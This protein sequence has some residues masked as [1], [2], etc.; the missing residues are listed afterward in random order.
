MWH[1]DRFLQITGTAA[2]LAGLAACGGGGQSVNGGNGLPRPNSPPTA[3]VVGYTPNDSPLA[4]FKPYTFTASGSDPDVGDSIKGFEW[5]FGDGSPLLATTGPSATHT[6]TTNSLTTTGGISGLRVRAIDSHGLAGA[7]SG[8]ALTVDNSPSPISVAIQDPSG[9]VNLQADPSGG[10]QIVFTVQVSTTSSGTISLAGVKFYPGESGAQILSSQSQGN[11]I[12]TFTVRYL[13]ASAPGSR[14]LTPTLSAQDSDGISSEVVQGPS[15]TVT[16]L[17]ISNHAPSIVVTNPVTPTSS[18][19]TSKPLDLAFTITDP[20]GDVVN[21][22]VDWGDGTTPTLG[23]VSAD[24]AHGVPVA[25]QHNF[26]DSFTSTTRNSIVTINATDGRSN[27]GV[28]PTQ[29]RVITVAFNT[30]PTATITSPQAS[31]FLPSTA[32]LPS[33]PGLGLFNPPGSSD[34]DILVIPSGGKVSFTGT[35]TLPASQDALQTFSW[36]FQGGIPSS[37]EGGPTPGEVVF[38]G[39]P[40][41]VSAYLVE[42][43]V[44]DGLGR[45]SALAPG[46]QPKLFRKW[47]VVDGKHTQQ[48][49][50]TFMYRMIADNNGQASLTPAALATHGMGSSVR[51]FQDGQ[52]NSYLVQDPAKTKAQ[53]SVPVR[54]NLPFYVL[55]PNFNSIVDNNTYLM[56]IPNAPD[57]I[58]AD[59]TLGTTLLANASSFGFQNSSAPWNPVLQIVTAQGFAP[60]LAASPERRL[61][62]LAGFTW[63]LSTPPNERYLDRLSVPLDGADSLGALDQWVQNN[64]SIGG[65]VGARAQQQIAEWLALVGNHATSDTSSAA[66]GPSQMRFTLNY[67]KYTGDAQASETFAHEALQVFRVPPGVTDPFNL[68]VAGWGSSSTVVGLN[69]TTL[70]SAYN[71]FLQKAVFGTPGASAFDGG[72]QNVSIPYEANDPDRKPYT[73]GRTYAFAP[74][75]SVFGFSEYL[76]SSVWARPLLLNVADP[77]FVETGNLDTFAHFRNSQPASWPQASGIVPDN[78]AFDMT[79]SG[80]GTFDASSPVGI[81][82]AVPGKKGVGRFYWTAYTPFYNAASDCVISRSWLSAADGLPP[83]TFNGGLGDATVAF[84]FLPPQDTVVDKRGRNADGSLNGNNLGGYR[85]T[86]FNPT[87]DPSSQPVPPDFWVVEFT[88]PDGSFHF[89]LPPSF[90]AGT[91]SLTDLVLTDARSFLP[92][93]RS[94]TQGPAADNS[95]RV[96]PGYCWFDVPP[97]L[98]PS[99]TKPES[100]SYLRVFAVKSILKNHPPAGARPLNRPDW[101]DAIKTALPEISI[102]ALNGD[103]SYAHKIPFNYYWDIVVVNGPKTP[104]AP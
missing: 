20:D 35:A 47:I 21:Y 76:W 80:G 79:V 54:S 33:D 77:N 27:N 9:S 83:T 70:P 84:G 18:A 24:T 50:L 49:K 60:E 69:P 67:P 68:D 72:L 82:G 13:G 46:V 22:T 42:F 31:A 11:G 65:I 58:Y 91:Q 17:S 14:V 104:V 99:I 7:F 44:I 45:S 93:G 25:L 51:V 62:G 39:N 56:R 48:F 102:L 86:W 75:R 12:Y 52:T 5:D 97:E 55:I 1:W 38:P 71:T 26:P 89:L 61:L 64:N 85:V 88:T 53:V 36:T 101:M 87:K 19:F 43:R 94:S 57:G 74:F 98:R 10:V 73:S 23:S 95:D 40:G 29:S 28:A 96:A 100:N 90:P 59:P 3:Q 92:S 8:Y 41:A 81:A 78:S 30:Y 2:L 32:D 6:F 15:I 63:G 103:V 4:R 37:Y 34:P 66:G 16:T